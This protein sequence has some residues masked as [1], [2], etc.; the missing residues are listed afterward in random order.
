MIRTNR[1]WL[2]IINKI[3]IKEKAK[4]PQKPQIAKTHVVNDFVG[5]ATYE[6]RKPHLTDYQ[7]YLI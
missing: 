6:E 4:N 7:Q 3:K 5:S 2:S 1:Y